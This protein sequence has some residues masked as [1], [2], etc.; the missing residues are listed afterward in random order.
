MS[1]ITHISSESMSY[2]VSGISAVGAAGTLNPKLNYSKQFGNMFTIRK[3]AH[4]FLDACLI[5]VRHF[6]CTKIYKD[7]LVFAHD[8]VYKELSK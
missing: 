4:A 5:I 1:R 3:Y 7:T 6:I 8:L 2:R